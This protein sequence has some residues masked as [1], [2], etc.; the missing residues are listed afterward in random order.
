[1]Y[2]GQCLLPDDKIKSLAKDLS[3]DTTLGLSYK[4]ALSE[5]KDYY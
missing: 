4:D 5:I 2:I 3:E 1:M